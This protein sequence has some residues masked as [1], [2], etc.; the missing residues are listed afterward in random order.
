MWGLFHRW[1]STGAEAKENWTLDALGLLGDD[2]TVRRLTPLILAW[3]GD[4]GHQ[5]AVTGV[6]VLSTIGTDVALMHLHGISQRARFKGLKTAAQTR[7][8]EVA[9]ARALVAAWKEARAQGLGVARI[10]DK[11]V[12]Q[13]HVDQASRLIA[14]ADTIAARG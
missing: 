13:L 5:K 8:A 2:E 3:P 7:M 11:M 4:G 12:E 14:L 1:Q 6:T 9:E 10:G